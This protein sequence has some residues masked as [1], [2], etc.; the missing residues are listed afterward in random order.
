MTSPDIDIQSLDGAMERFVT[1]NWKPAKAETVVFEPL[2]GDGST[3]RFVRA[4]CGAETAIVVWGPDPGENRAYE[5]IGN[6]LW[7]LGQMGPEF[8][9]SDPDAGLFLIEDL[10]DVPLAEW[11]GQES[12]WGQGAM[13]G[14]TVARMADLHNSGLEGFNPDWC[15]QTRQYDRDLILERETGYFLNAFINGYLG[16]NIEA[17]RLG[18]EFSALADTALADSE[19]VLM[20]RDFQS[21]NVMIKDGW[22]R[23]IDFQGA[24]L[25]PP[26]YDLAS[27]LYDPYAD[28]EPKRRK[29]LWEYYVERR[30]AFRPDFD[31]NRLSKS[32]PY[33]AACRLLQALGAF[34]FLT[35]VQ[36]KPWF[37]KHIPAAL[38]I[39]R[40]LLTEKKFDFVPALRVLVSQAAEETRA[41]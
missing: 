36:K 3:R 1:T 39:L 34:G 25:G 5:M 14:R 19:T 12:D 37:E 9:S 11:A 32:V 16:K 20:H 41:E 6:H 38:R 17:Q 23:L 35:R 24:R 8:F 2:A 27:L 21:R 26:G 10:G 22:P 13:Y 33:L 31:E 4:R 30:L 15:F 7:R 29:A 18:P 28:L 40:E